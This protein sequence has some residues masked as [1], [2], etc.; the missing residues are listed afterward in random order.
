M[1]RNIGRH[2][3]YNIV[4]DKGFMDTEKKKNK[5]TGKKSTRKVERHVSYNY[6]F[7]DISKSLRTQ[8]DLK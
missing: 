7:F 5:D 1:T 8:L 3:R 6:I 4:D 2:L